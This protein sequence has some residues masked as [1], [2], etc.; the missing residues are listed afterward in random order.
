[1]DALEKSKCKPHDADVVSS[2]RLVYILAIIVWTGIIFAFG[3]HRMKAK[4]LLLIPYIL[5]GIAIFNACKLET[6]VER[7]M[8]QTTFLSVGLILAIPLL[9]WTSQD[10]KG[11]KKQFVNIIIMSVVFSSFSM[12]DLWV[13]RKWL[14]LY[15]HIRSSFQVIG[16]TLLVFGLIE[17]FLCRE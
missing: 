5:F 6:K 8:F 16:L 13:S 17:Y 4:F 14:P 10:Y 15:Y 12:Y 3:F 2:I 7:V 11:D 1:M 9:T